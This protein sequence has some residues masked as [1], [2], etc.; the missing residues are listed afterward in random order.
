MDT[1]TKSTAV[2]T[3][4]TVTIDQDPIN[5]GNQTAVG[6]T[7]AGAE[8]GAT[9]DY[10][11]TSDGGGT[12]VTGNGTIVTATDNITGID[13]SGLGDGTITLSVTLTNV[14][15]TGAA[16]LD[17][18]TKSTA[19]PSGYTVTIDQDPI[20]VGNQTAV[21]FTFA[22]AEVGATYDYSFT[23]D[24]GG[25]P[26]T[27]N[28]TI[29]TATDN[30]TG[31]D[32]SGLGDGTVTLSVT[33]TN[34]DGTGAAAL[35][36]A[37]KSTTVPTGY[38]VTIDQDPINV[39]NQTAVGFTFAGAEVGATYD[40][41]F[42]SDGGGTPVTGNGTIVT[43]TDNITGID[44][45]GLGD[46]TVTLSVTLTNGNGTGVAALDTS[47]KSTAVPTGY[48]ATIDQDPINAAN[49]AAVGFTFAG[50][51][52]GA[53]YDY[54]FTSDGGGTPVTG[55]GTIVTATDNITGIDL[56]GLGDGTITLSVTLT[57]GDGTG[58]AALDTSTK[59]TAVPTGYTVTIDQDP[60][61]AA[62]QTAVGFTFA[63]AEVGAT[64]DYS[65][66]SDGGGTPVTGNGTIVTA[67][68]NITGID[69]SGLGDGTV[70]L[71]VTLTNGNGTGAAAQD[72]STKFTT[73]PV[74]Y[75]VSID[76]DPIN[77]PDQSAVGFTFA[78]AEVGATYDYSF[79]SDGGGTPVTGN[80]TIVTATD[81]ITGIDLSGLG[82]G[83]ITLSVTLTN[84]NGTGIAAL[85]TSTKFTTVPTGYTVTI[86][87]DPID[88]NNQTVVSF[89][90]AGATSG[91]TYNYTFS[92]DG[93]GTPVTGN[94]TI[95]TATDNITGINLSGLTNGN[96]TL[97]VTL[98]N[99]NGAGTPATDTATK[100]T[101]FAGTVAPVI[102]SDP[103]FDFCD[104]FTQDLDDYTNTPVPP[105]SVLQ[106]STNPNPLIVAGHLANSTISDAPGTY[107]GFFYDGVNNCA[108]PTLTV[109]ITQNSTPD[110]GITNN[111]QVCSNAADGNTL[112]DLDDRITG[113]DAG[114]WAL[115]SS[116]PGSS[117]TI[118]ASNIINFDG[119][120]EGDYIFT[121]TTNTA[122]AP[123]VD[124]DVDLTITVIDCALPCDAG[125]VAPT[126]DTS[127]PTEF[128]DTILADLNDYVTSSAPAGSILTW[129]TN[130]DPLQTA[131][132]RPSLVNAPGSYFGFFYDAANGCASPT[133]T[134]TLIQNTTPT[135]TDSTG[136]S[137]CSGESVTLSATASDAATINWYDSPT[138]GTILGIGGT[139]DTPPITVT[140]SFYVEA[141]LNDCPS[142]RVEVVATVISPLITDTSGAFE[143][144]R[145]KH[146]H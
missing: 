67:T 65:F 110:P 48:T 57:N 70:T 89:T 125:N 98:T 135:I 77:A 111:F 114:S 138:G 12:P 8:V 23:S 66:T 43:A 80:G 97:S 28:G 84:G 90:F 56:S 78:G 120:P 39:G 106:W 32:L 101:C 55:N 100:D 124:Q 130:P 92:S 104:A 41:S 6:F 50:A 102:V 116:Q 95:V 105:G 61:N 54:S 29:V 4:Y 36:T 139:F 127:E 82:D 63:G 128:C 112:V 45:S 133:L 49:Q 87:Q 26:V 46:G 76:Q 74:G 117:I 34:G 94:G 144:W 146:L 24:G 123:C 31:I 121:Y 27:G 99:V 17:T 119:Q 51:E 71:S 68:D 64:Y 25:T 52:I 21:S 19:V 109:V 86:D 137:G 18:A 15:G 108:S 47:A 37:T 96:I 73:V 93:G 58:A 42:T 118:N 132:H 91:T 2:P 122:T 3:G 9:Y 103:I 136:A 113:Q 35:D 141:T 38:T 143:M 72:T 81:N 10:S 14:N 5:V 60:I 53:T 107:Y 62:N 44:L 30:I 115:T 33:L 83:T 69:L 40:Y 126:L 7:F 142:A 20:N 88:E 1:A 85:D 129:S 145:R 131:A 134:V 79:T 16:A 11:F 13:L 59:F 140:T 75:S 22:G